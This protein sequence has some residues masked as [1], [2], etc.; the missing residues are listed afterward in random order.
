[1]GIED[2]TVDRIVRG[3]GVEVKIPE[4]GATLRQ[5]EDKGLSGRVAEEQKGD[6]GGRAR[7]EEIRQEQLDR[8]R[9]V[10]AEIRDCGD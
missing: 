10:L 1:M 9:E 4:G 8:S 2:M 5:M 7:E 3:D 6:E